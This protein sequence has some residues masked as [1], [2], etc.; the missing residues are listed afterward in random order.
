[1]FWM[2]YYIFADMQFVPANGCD[3]CTFTVSQVH[4]YKKNEPY[5]EHVFGM[6]SEERAQYLA[7][8]QST[9][10]VFLAVVGT[11]QE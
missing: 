9:P 6:L 8:T 10:P 3:N 5:R 2:S 1:M 4:T 11:S 7:Q